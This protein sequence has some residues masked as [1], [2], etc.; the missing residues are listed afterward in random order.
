MVAAL[1]SGTAGPSWRI[2]E[3]QNRPDSV[4]TSANLLLLPLVKE[5]MEV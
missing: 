1:M 3:V 5:M 4:E 2:I